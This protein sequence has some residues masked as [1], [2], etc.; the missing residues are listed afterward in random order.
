[1]AAGR[2]AQYRSRVA[3]QCVSRGGAEPACAMH[4]SCYVRRRQKTQ[5]E[6]SLSPANKMKRIFLFRG[7]LEKEVIKRNVNIIWMEQALFKNKYVYAYPH[8]RVVTISVDKVMNVKE[9]KKGSNLY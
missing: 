2:L 5:N 7:G 4:R 9:R 8:I 1:M 6:S 3:P